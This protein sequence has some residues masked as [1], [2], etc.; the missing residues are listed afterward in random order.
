MRSLMEARKMVINPKLFIF[1]LVSILYTVHGSEVIKIGTFVPKSSPWGQVLT[2]WE[3]A[4]KEKSG[5]KV[6]LQFFYNGQQGTEAAVVGKMKSGQLDG[7]FVT[8]VGL[9]KIYKPILALQMPGLFKTWN[10]ID[11][12]RQ[13]MSSDFEKGLNDAGFTLIGWS[14]FGAVH[15]F[16]KGITVKTPDDVKGKK[17]FVDRDDPTAPVLYQAIGGVTPVPLNIVEVLPMLKVVGTLNIVNTPSLVA[18]QL[19]WS[20]SLNTINKNVNAFITGG[21]I[22]SSQRLNALPADLRSIIVDTG[23]IAIQ[24]LAKRIRA[25][26]DAA[27]IRLQSKMTVVTPTAD[28]LVQWN[29]IYKNVRERLAQSTFSSDL[30]A[31]LEQLGNSEG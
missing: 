12:A 2:V 27:F 10:N 16:S 11:T 26:D 28:E 19:Q 24:S 29:N 25:E 7:A 15:L 21:L 3:Y 22:F 1:I 23:K 6:E 13:A 5:G 14:D 8:A 9:G 18:E 30:V 17:P 20:T 31:K 4:V